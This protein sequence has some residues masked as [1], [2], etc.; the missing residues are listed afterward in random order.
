M[1]TLTCIALLFALV[2]PSFAADGLPAG[3]D[4]K[5]VTTYEQTVAK[6]ITFLEGSR[7]PADGSYSSFAGIG[8]TALVT[9]ALL[10]HG[11]SPDDPLLATSLD[12]LKGH[13][14]EDGG[15]YVTGTHYRNYETCVAMVC[16]AEANDDG[17]YDKILK[18]ADKFIKG[19][20]WDEGE[21]KEK[22]DPAFGGAGYGKH[23]RPDLS[24]TTFLI[25][26]LKSAGN[27]P[28]DQAM[29]QALIFVSRCQN[30]ESEHNDTKHAA[31]IG[32]GSFYYTCA[33]GGETKT[34]ET[35]NGGLRGY[36]SMTYAG[37]KSMIYAGVDADD[38]RVQAAK[39]WISKHY[40]LKENPG[41]ADSGLYY[42]YHVFAKALSALGE[43]EFADADG[44][45]HPWR[46][47][48]INELAARQAE[49]GSW[50]N[51]NSRWL[52]GDANLVTAYSLLAL[53]YCHPTKQ[54]AGGGIEADGKAVES[55]TSGGRVDPRDVIRP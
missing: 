23:L 41:M 52:E 8:P 11:R 46:A 17:R 1:K 2:A 13:I 7:N 15:I 6:A 20:Q 26:A 22:S 50:T 3:F 37:L 44:K 32:D 12:Y 16:F 19:L 28:D 36:G 14:Q 54:A 5:T 33:T 35:A 49:N 29:Q 10:R 39:K 48:L 42:Y 27:G 53:S 21:G 40:S 25:D 55:G 31:L 30:L 24:N 18:N 43:E 47:E 34:E 4:D 45:L 38:K 51:E 9:T